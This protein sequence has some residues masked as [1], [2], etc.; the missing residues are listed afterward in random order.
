MRRWLTVLL[1]V[2][3]P[4]QLGW[5]ALGSYCQHET[6]SQAQHL[7]HHAHPHQG[8]ASKQGDAAE[9]GK[10]LH[11]DC[12]ACFATSI[13]SLLDD[14]LSIAAPPVAFEMGTFQARPLFRPVSPPERPDW[15][16]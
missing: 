13:A 5:A 14:P 12:N 2:L 11:G 8:L 9:K 6:G 4:L 16:A 1:L 7:G 15:R 3:L 10:S